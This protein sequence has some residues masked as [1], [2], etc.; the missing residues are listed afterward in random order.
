ME[1]PSNSIKWQ[2]CIAFTLKWEGGYVNNPDD[3]G[4]ETNMGISKRS[5]PNEDIK[6]MTI[7]R[8]EIIY[9]NDYWL[10]T[11]CEDE[12]VSPKLALA[13]FDTAVNCG[14][15]SVVMWKRECG[16]SISPVAIITKR[17]RRYVNL[18]QKNHKFKQ[19]L[20]GWFVR[21]VQIL[22]KGDQL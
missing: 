6:N 5:Y 10:P 12:N 21:A 8:A 15:E 7:E 13:L 14:R 20:L 3:P 19:F 22:E 9:F 4:G 2:K 16:S 1:Q 17:L 11:G 18:G